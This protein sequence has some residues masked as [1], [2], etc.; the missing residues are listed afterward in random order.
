MTDGSEISAVIAGEVGDGTDLLVRLHSECFTGDVM[1]SQRCDCR[2]Q[3]ERG[4]ERIE[5]EG[6]GIV[7]YLPQEGRGI[8][9]INKIRAYALQDRGRDTVDANLE[10]GFAVDHR[11]YSSA[12]AALKHLG[13]K[14][15]RLMSNNPLKKKGLENGGVAVTDLVPHQ[16]E[17][18]AENA[19][20]LETKRDR[21]GHLL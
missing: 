12:A 17:A 20:Y 2:A 19:F 3:L 7:L 13:V 11:D 18:T 15:V 10:L 16:T 6:R 9:L 21:C 5:A 8:G 1:G 4:L 14:S